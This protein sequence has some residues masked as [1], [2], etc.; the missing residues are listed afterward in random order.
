MHGVH[1]TQRNCQ[2]ELMHFVGSDQWLINDIFVLG[3]AILHH[4]SR[5]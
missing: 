3:L 1:F 5:T 2:G 4:Q